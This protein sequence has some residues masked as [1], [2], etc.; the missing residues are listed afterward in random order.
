[1][2]PLVA[3][4]QAYAEA[5]LAADDDR[6]VQTQDD[7][8]ERIGRVVGPQGLAALT[9]VSTMTGFTP[10][11]ELIALTRWARTRVLYLVDDTVADEL[12]ATD[13]TS[14][15]PGEV[16]TRLPYPN[17]LVMLPREVKFRHDA[18]GWEVYS[19][20]LVCG[21]RA[22]KRRCS[23]DDE[24]LSGLVLFFLG[25]WCDD[26]GE[27]VELMVTDTY[28]GTAR[29]TRN[30]LGMRVTLTCDDASV[31]QRQQA[32][33]AEMMS[34]T[35]WAHDGFGTVEAAQDACEHLCATGLSLLL[36][37]VADNSDQRP[38][39]PVRRSKRDRRANVAPATVVELGYRVGAA[40]RAARTADAGGPPPGGGRSVAAHVRRGHW[41]TFRVGPRRTGRIVKWLPPT[42]VNW[43][44]APRVTQI[45]RR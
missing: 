14:V 21:T 23:T 44:S 12:L 26:A 28:S 18:G 10:G 3:D 27:E 38:A 22:D 29:K 11:E 31:A 36:Y 13:P 2:R 41:H 35:P 42:A 19:A 30:Q 15:I 32:A 9:E 34:G 5:V 24:D 7:F 1:M 37:L 45:V 4:P 16:V 17:P 40:L 39:P 20:M 8:T 6:S 43:K 33:V 25:Y